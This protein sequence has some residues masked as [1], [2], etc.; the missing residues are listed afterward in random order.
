MILTKIVREIAQKGSQ[1]AVLDTALGYFNDQGF[2]ALSYLIPSIKTPG[3]IEGEHFG[4]PEAWWAHYRGQEYQQIDPFPA[5]VVRSGRPMRITDIQKEMALTGEQ[6]EYLQ[7]ARSHGVTDGFILPTFGPRQHIALFVAAQVD[8]LAILDTV[9]VELLQFVAQT[10][11]LRIDQINA[12]ELPRPRLAPR[13][14][15]ILHWIAQGKSNDSI[16]TILGIAR[17]TVATHIKRIFQKLDVGDRASAAVKGIKFGII[18][19]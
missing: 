18:D 17:P 12:C 16:A 3:Q 6:Q 14:V 4:Y 8:D 11:H 5:F 19:A 2:R 15:V 9:E 10:A 1:E 7:D 13:E